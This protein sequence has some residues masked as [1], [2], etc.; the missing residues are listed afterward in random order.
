MPVIHP[1]VQD[2]TKVV[3]E[4]LHLVINQ[5]FYE[6]LQKGFFALYHH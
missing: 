6:F 2:N 3:R 1:Y 4:V 5:A